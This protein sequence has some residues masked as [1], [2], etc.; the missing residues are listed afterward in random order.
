MNKLKCEQMFVAAGVKPG[1]EGHGGKN[2]SNLSDDNEASES[3]AAAT[4]ALKGLRCYMCGGRGHAKG[5]RPSVKAP[6][7]TGCDGVG[8]TA[9]ACPAVLEDGVMA[10]AAPVADED[11]MGLKHDPRDAYGGKVHNYYTKRASRF[12]WGWGWGRYRQ[13]NA[14]VL[15]G[16][17]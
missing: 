6:R 4:N 9:A 7:Y 14:S 10:I 8:H 3:A 16:F 5:N 15:R 13:C 1:G 2:E 17:L 12:G 11:E